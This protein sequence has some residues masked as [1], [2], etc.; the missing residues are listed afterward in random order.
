MIGQLNYREHAVESGYDAPT[1]VSPVP[2]R[3]PDLLRPSADQRPPGDYSATALNRTSEPSCRP[4]LGSRPGRRTGC[5]PSMSD[6]RGS[7]LVGFAGTHAIPADNHEPVDN[8]TSVVP[9]AHP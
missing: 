2:Y 8:A 1:S 9:L 3:Q 5:G 6:P 7:V 4:A